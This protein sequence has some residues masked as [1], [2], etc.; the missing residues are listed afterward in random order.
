MT[1]TSIRRFFWGITVFLAGIVLIL[2]AGEILP[3]SSW[4]FIW[5]IFVI[6]IGF[7]LMFTAIYK[8]GEEIEIEV[9]KFWYKKRK[10]RK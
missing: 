10:K 3:G 7:E 8:P 9:P 1:P 2:Q 6:I 4:K 5:P